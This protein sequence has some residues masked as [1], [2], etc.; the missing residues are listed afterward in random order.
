MTYLFYSCSF[1][2]IV[3]QFYVWTTSYIFELLFVNKQLTTATTKA[4]TADR[5]R[6][7]NSNKN[8]TRLAKSV[9]L[10]INVVIN[11]VASESVYILYTIY[12]WTVWLIHNCLL[13]TFGREFLRDLRGLALKWLWHCSM[14]AWHKYAFNDQ[15]CEY[16]SILFLFIKYSQ[17]P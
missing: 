10:N 16:E 2:R 7:I 3:C 15:M 5:Y 6:H 13:Y 1:Y 4:S 11:S 14:N 8:N 17:T 9:A 12:I